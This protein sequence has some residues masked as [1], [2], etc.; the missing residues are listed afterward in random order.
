MLFRAP[1]ALLLLTGRF[2]ALRRAYVVCGICASPR[3]GGSR[4]TTAAADHSTHDA[5]RAA[6]GT[7]HGPES[8]FP[9]LKPC[10][11]YTFL[12][13]PPCCQAPPLPLSLCCAPKCFG[14]EFPISYNINITYIV[15]YIY[16][17]I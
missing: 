2:R 14:L 17:Y 9:N 15:L 8:E 7:A 10:V 16:M 3:G 1:S 12:K 6:Y 11:I 4:H 5:R 13:A